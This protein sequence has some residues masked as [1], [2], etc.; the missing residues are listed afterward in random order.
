M[1]ACEM[2]LHAPGV[3]RANALLDTFV[4]LDASA[5]ALVERLGK[6]AGTAARRRRR[7]LAVCGAG[8]AGWSTSR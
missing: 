5:R 3:G 8:E 6:E 1:R 2:G 4:V 7:Q